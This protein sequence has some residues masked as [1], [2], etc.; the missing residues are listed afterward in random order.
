MDAPVE[1]DN[2][3]ANIKRR[4]EEVVDSIIDNEIPMANNRR[5]LSNPPL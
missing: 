1:T 5:G 3:F 4:E 2:A